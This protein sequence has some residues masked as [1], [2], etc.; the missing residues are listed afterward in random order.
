MVGNKYSCSEVIVDPEFGAFGDNG[1]VD[2][3]KT[4]VDKE[5]D[6]ASLLPGSFTYEKY[7]AGNYCKSL[8]DITRDR[9]GSCRVF[10]H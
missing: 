10:H 4:C 1:C 3:V 7:F 6:E 5:V 9:M 8:L 2:F